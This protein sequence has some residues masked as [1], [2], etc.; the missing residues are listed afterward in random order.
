VNELEQKVVEKLREVKDPENGLDIIEEGLVY[1]FTIKENSIK[2]FIGIESATPTCNF[3]KAISWLTIDKISKEIG[4][5]LKE[6]GFEE[7]Q[8]VE[9][10][11]PK[12]VYFST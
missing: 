4:E 2:V 9:E 3:C 6:L 1:G 5:K 7:I 11:N 8:V 12:I 10:L